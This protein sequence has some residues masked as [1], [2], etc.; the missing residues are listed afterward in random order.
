MGANKVRDNTEKEATNL[1]ADIA[2][3][4]GMVLVTAPIETHWLER[5]QRLLPDLRIKQW[6]IHSDG[7]IPRDLWQEVEIL[8]TSFAASLPSP[9]NA[10][11][12]RWVQLYS[13]GPDRILDHPLFST[14]VT[15]TTVSGIHAITMAEYVFAVV[16]AWFHRLPRVLDWQQGRQWPSNRERATLFVGEELWGKTIA[17]VGYGS[18]SRQVAR[19]AK[20]FGMRVLATQRGSDH[21]DHGFRFPGVGDPEGTL[22]DGYY[23]P[24]QFHQMLSESDIVVIAVPLTSKTQGMFDEAAFRMMKPTAFLVNIA[25]GDVCK[26]VDLIRALEERQIAGAAL[27]VFHEEPLPSDHPLWHLENVFISP[28]VAGLSPRYNEYAASVFEENLQRY[29]AGEP[30]INV[31]DKVSEY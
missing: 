6:S 2:Y 26:E 27:D 19:L 28:H 5:L 9:E 22:P 17:V 13:A 20:S 12:L 23:A 29:L 16:L 30:L 31:V 1:M 25:R 4:S 11:R 7:V 24:D 8:Y 14:S 3:R 10:S 15:F 21:R 18:V